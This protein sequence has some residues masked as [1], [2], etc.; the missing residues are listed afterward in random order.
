M[1]RFGV[2]STE[3]M[4]SPVSEIKATL[5]KKRFRSGKVNRFTCMVRAA[6]SEMSSV[7]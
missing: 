2:T 3:R 5:E 1:P 7:S 6:S 4:G